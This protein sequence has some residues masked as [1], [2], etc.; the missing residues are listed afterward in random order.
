M[1][2]YIAL[3]TQA[4]ESG[5]PEALIEA[6]LKQGE[7]RGFGKGA[8]VMG[9]GLAAAGGMYLGGKYLWDRF[10]KTQ[11]KSVTEAAKAA[12]A[13]ANARG[14][15]I[16][17]ETHEMQGT[18]TLAAGDRFRALTR[19]EDVVMIEVDGREDNPFFVSGSLL[20]QISDFA[21]ADIA[22]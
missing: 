7:D 18:L 14:W 15:N 9:L 13:R 21:I 2:D 10:A 17:H 6:L 3:S 11:P 1:D 12:V 4:K 20:E 5:G 16:V 8:A 22:A 19:D